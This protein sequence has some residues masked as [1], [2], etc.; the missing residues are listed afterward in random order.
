V[1]SQRPATTIQKNS[2]MLKIKKNHPVSAFTLV[3]PAGNAQINPSAARAA[4]SFPLGEQRPALNLP[5]MIRL[6]KLLFPH[7]HRHEQRRKLQALK[8]VVIVGLLVA[9]AVAPGFYWLDV[10]GRH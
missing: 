9:T 8:G 10:H 3:D 5:V 1:E 7:A 2:G 4:R 6:E